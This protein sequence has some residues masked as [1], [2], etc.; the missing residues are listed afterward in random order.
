[1]QP[2][3]HGVGAVAGGLQFGPQGP[4]HQRLRRYGGR[5]WNCLRLGR[6]GKPERHEEER[7][8]AAHTFILV[9]VEPPRKVAEASAVYALRLSSGQVD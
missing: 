7:Q 1:M 5:H 3:A 6:N 2:V 9:G 4:V 8:R